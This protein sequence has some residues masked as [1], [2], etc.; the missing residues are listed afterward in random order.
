MA[1]REQ[2][3]VCAIEFDAID[4]VANSVAYQG[5]MERFKSH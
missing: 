5:S 4:F 2:T 1:S 3:S